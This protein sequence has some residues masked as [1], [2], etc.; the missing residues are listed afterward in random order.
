V[1]Q[2]VKAA[3]EEAL[4]GTWHRV[5][6][7]Q[8]NLAATP[9]TVIDQAGATQRK[10]ALPSKAQP[11]DIKDSLQQAMSHSKRPPWDRKD[12]EKF[13]ESTIDSTACEAR[14]A[15]CTQHC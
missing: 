15:A 4:L 10:G 3:G 12:Y 14:A 8:T 2:F 5:T 7:E 6:T 9:M 11:A 13:S 1:R